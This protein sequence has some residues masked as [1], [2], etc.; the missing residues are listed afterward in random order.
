[1]AYSTDV[2]MLYNGL[3]VYVDICNNL[4][5]KR[6]LVNKA[7]CVNKVHLG[8]FVWTTFINMFDF[9]GLINFY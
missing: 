3:N 8:V 6:P 2:S 5:A 7:K 1:M 4:L 9:I